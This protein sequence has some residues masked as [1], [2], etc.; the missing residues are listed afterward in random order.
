MAGSPRVTANP[1]LG[2]AALRENALALIRWQPVQ[3]QAIVTSGGTLILRRT[4]P[5]RHPP[6]QGKSGR[7]ANHFTPL[8]ARIQDSRT[9]LQ[10]LRRPDPA[11]HAIAV[12]AKRWY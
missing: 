3:W 2:I 7:F 10:R 5:Q 11:L 1:S 12:A 9:I 8:P 6:S 4:C